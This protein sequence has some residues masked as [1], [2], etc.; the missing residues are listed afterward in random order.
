MDQHL[1]TLIQKRKD[2][3]QE[4]DDTNRKLARTQARVEELKVSISNQKLSVEDV[5]KMQNEVKGVKEAIDRAMAL[6]DQRRQVV[7]ET[8]SEFETLWN[9]LE[10][11]VSDYNSQQSELSLLPLVSSKGVDMKAKVDKGAILEGNQTTMLGVDL[12][13]IVQP[14]LS[15]CKEEYAEKLSESKWKYQEA[16][17]QLER[18]EEAFTEALEKLKIIEDRMDKCEDTLTG[19]REAQDAKLAVRQR[20]AE[21]METRV[22]SLRDPVALEEQMAQ[23]ERQCAELEALRMKYDEDNVSRK[24]AVCDEIQKACE[25]MQLYDEYCME[26]IQEVQQYRKKKKGQYGKLKPPQGML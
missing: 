26:K 19:E 12:P 11:L 21:S 25:E 13:S 3:A 24:E 22:A 17:D 20:E 7:W 10:A 2:R 4:L 1:E 8:E 5:Q 9:D 18:S 6:K 14:L 16:L 15:S 23:Y